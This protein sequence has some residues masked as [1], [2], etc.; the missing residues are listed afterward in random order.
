MFESQGDAHF[1]LNSRFTEKRIEALNPDLINVEIPDSY[2][3]YKYDNSKSQLKLLQNM[4]C[5]EF[6][7]MMQKTLRKVDLA[8][9]ANSVEIRV[10]FLKKTFIQM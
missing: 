3:N 7:G 9:M 5:A 2:E 8:S 4:R 1:N 6:Y 10:P